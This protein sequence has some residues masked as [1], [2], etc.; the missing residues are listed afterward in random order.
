MDWT[1][2]L[3]S[4]LCICSRINILY[5]FAQSLRLWLQLVQIVDGSGQLANLSAEQLVHNAWTH[6]IHQICVPSSRRQ[7][8]SQRARQIADGEHPEN[9]PPRLRGIRVHEIQRKTKRVRMRRRKRC[10]PATTTTT[11]IRDGTIYISLPFVYPPFTG[12]PCPLFFSALRVAKSALSI[13]DATVSTPPTMAHVL[14]G[15]G[16]SVSET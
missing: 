2:C 6:T 10:R 1:S 5:S 7:C 9:H 8:H 14:Q 3:F 12:E 11:Y 16:Q 4:R 13:S 15:W